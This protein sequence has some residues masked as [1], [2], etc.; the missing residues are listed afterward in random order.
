MNA[1]IIT[2]GTELLL[3]HVINTDAAIIAREL[4]A[5]GINLFFIHTVGD[6]AERIEK[7]LTDALSRSDLILISG[8]LGPTP[9]DLT[10]E[11]V[12]KTLGKKLYTDENSLKKLEKYFQG[13]PI[14]ANQ[15]KQAQFPEGSIILNNA[16]GTAPGCIVEWAGKT[17]IMLPGPPSEL[18]PMLENE[19]RPWLARKNCGVIVTHIIRTFGIGEGDA[20]VKIDSILNSANPTIAPYAADGEM[21]VKITA[22]ADNDLNAEKL[23]KPVI[24][25][26]ENLLEDYCYGRDS[27]TLASK[28]V[29][30]LKERR[31]MLASAESCTGGWLAQQITSCAGSS[32][33]FQLGI[34]SYANSA[35]E[36]ILSIPNNILEKYGAVSFETAEYM[37]KGI[38]NLSGSNLGISITGIAGPDGGSMEKPLG[39]VYFCLYDGKQSIMTKME[40]R[41]IWPGRDKIRLKAVKTALDMIR[42]YLTVLPI[43]DKY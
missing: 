41:P 20:A 19:V 36:K 37:A 35:K 7:T 26:V 28:V 27:D 40:P 1:E 17:I 38:H 9:D 15:I 39:L 24:N 30:L 13:R 25:E 29:S 32:A 22:R 16:H 21:F 6:N 14:S 12:A 33:V 23:L 43:P 42:R 3:G 10:C 2:T 4:A 31:L 34:V 11:V 8:G 5:Q 18:A